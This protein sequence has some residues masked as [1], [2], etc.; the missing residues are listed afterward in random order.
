MMNIQCGRILLYE[1]RYLFAS[2]C[3]LGCLMSI[4]HKA[5]KLHR[6]YASELLSTAFDCTARS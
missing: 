4:I 2:S 3:H 6:P 1:F 5:V